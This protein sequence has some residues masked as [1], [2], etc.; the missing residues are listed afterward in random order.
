MPNPLFGVSC[1]NFTSSGRSLCGG[2]SG[3]VV[4]ARK[5]GDCNRIATPR[6]PYCHADVSLLKYRACNFAVSETLLIYDLCRCNLLTFLKTSP[7]PLVDLRTGFGGVSPVWGREPSVKTFPGSGRDC[8]PD[9]LTLLWQY[10]IVFLLCNGI[11]TV[12]IAEILLY[13]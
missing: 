7:V 3:V 6:P 9:E 12:N 4:V 13:F 1:P 2:L 5:V 11:L 8:L 10:G